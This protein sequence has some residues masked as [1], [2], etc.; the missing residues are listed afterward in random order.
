MKNIISLGL[1]FLFLG[2]LFGCSELQEDITQPE[3]VGIHEE[4]ILDK[5]SE[6]F[7]G[8]I[9]ANNNWNMENCQQC[10]AADYSGGTAESSCLKCHSQPDGPEACNTCHGS[11]QNPD[12]I[13]P[14]KSVAG[15]TSTT[16]PGVGAH[17]VHSYENALSINYS[18]AQCHPF[19]TSS[20]ENFVFAHADGTPAEMQFGDIAEMMS[21]NPSYSFEENT[22]QNSYCHGNFEFKREDAASNAQF[23]YEDSVIVGNNFS[24]VWNQVDGSQAACG[25]CHGLPPTGHSG[26]YDKTGCANCHNSVV[27][28]E[29]NI[30]DKMKH[31]NG[32]ANVF[33]N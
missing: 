12:R 26:D 11:Y 8:N 32:E 25:T 18:C 29:G 33:G 3:D 24:P 21:T 22:C 31:I 10:H 15:D 19:Q 4:G 28:G 13:A 23:A 30:I 2:L 6:N 17:T 1:I 5:A 7:H 9:I 27:D 20:D 14:P 16:V